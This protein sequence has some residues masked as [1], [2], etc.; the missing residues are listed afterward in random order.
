MT[1]DLLP[2][3]PEGSPALPVDLTYE[4]QIVLEF[5]REGK[6]RNEIST[7]TGVSTW[8]V[9]KIASEHGHYFGRSAQI[10]AASAARV[11]QIRER[12]HRLAMQLLDTAELYADRL[13]EANSPKDGQ[14]LARAVSDLVS[15]HQLLNG[16]SANE[17]EE[18]KDFLVDLRV[19]L[20]KVR[21]GF[22]NQYGVPFES[23]EAAQIIKQEETQDDES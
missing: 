10:A 5:C 11:A 16:T 14:A 3:Q 21:D 9:S 13:A 22:E 19:Q 23:D 15:S 8:T 17:L 2:F 1:G 4:E 6:S 18:T 7:L 12:Q 20:V